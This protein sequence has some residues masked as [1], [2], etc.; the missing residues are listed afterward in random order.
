VT[1]N[2]VLITSITQTDQNNPARIFEQV[3]M[4]AADFKF[5]FIP[6]AANGS[7]EQRSILSSTAR[8]TKRGNQSF[9]PRQT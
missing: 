8:R 6:Q 2:D 7:A 5:H 4:N 9:A 3:Q 1:L